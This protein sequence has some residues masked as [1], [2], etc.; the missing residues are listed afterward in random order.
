MKDSGK[1]QQTVAPA[2]VKCTVC[3]SYYLVRTTSAALSAV[4]TAYIDDNASV[5]SAL[6]RRERSVP[7]TRAS[8]AKYDMK[9]VMEEERQLLIREYSYVWGRAEKPLD[10]CTAFGK[11][12]IC[13]KF[14]AFTEQ[15][16]PKCLPKAKVDW[17]VI[18]LAP[19]TR[20]CERFIESLDKTLQAHPD[21]ALG[22]L[23]ANDLKGLTTCPV[24][25]K[26]SI[27]CYFVL[28][29]T[30]FGKSSHVFEHM[31][32]RKD[33]FVYTAPSLEMV[34][35]VAG[36]G[37][38]ASTFQK[39][40]TERAEILVIDEC[41][42]FSVERIWLMSKNFAR[43]IFIGDWTRVEN[44][45]KQ[46]T[47]L[48]TEGTAWK[49]DAAY[50]SHTHW[51]TEARRFAKWYGDL[52]CNI[53]YPLEG[54][55]GAASNKTTIVEIV[56]CESFE[57]ARNMRKQNSA[58]KSSAGITYLREEADRTTN[59][60]QPWITQKEA[61]GRTYEEVHLWD[62]HPFS[63][64]TSTCVA[65]TRMTTRLVIYV[66]QRFASTFSRFLQFNRQTLRP[67]TQAVTKVPS[68]DLQNFP[69]LEDPHFV[70]ANM[71]T[72]IGLVD[73]LEKSG[74]KLLRRKDFGVVEGKSTAE[75]KFKWLAETC[76]EI[77]GFQTNCFDFTLEFGLLERNFPLRGSGWNKAR[78][79]S[80]L[81][82]GKP[83]Q[84][85]IDHLLP[86][87]WMDPPSQPMGKK[88][89]V[90]WPYR[91]TEEFENRES[92][93][94]CTINEKTLFVVD[95]PM[96][97][98]FEGV[99]P[100]HG[101]MYPHSLNSFFR[102]MGSMYPKFN[103][104][105]KVM[106]H[107]GAHP[108]TGAKLFSKTNVR[109][110]G[111][112]HELSP[113][114]HTGNLWERYYLIVGADRDTTCFGEICVPPMINSLVQDSRI[115][116]TTEKLDY[117][118]MLLAKANRRSG[119]VWQYGSTFYFVP[120]KGP[121]SPMLS[122]KAKRMI[123]SAN[124]DLRERCV[125]VA[126]YH[127]H[128]DEGV[129]HSLMDCGLYNLYGFADHYISSGGEM[130]I[131]RWVDGALSQVIAPLASCPMVVIKEVKDSRTHRAC[132][133]NSFE[134]PRVHREEIEQT[135]SMGHMKLDPTNVK[136][137][138]VISCKAPEKIA[139]SLINRPTQYTPIRYAPGEHNAFVACV[140]RF[141]TSQPVIS[142][143]TIT[144]WFG[145]SVWMDEF[146]HGLDVIEK[147]GGFLNWASRFPSN[148][149]RAFIRARYGNE[150][151]Y[152]R[153][154][155]KHYGDQF[156]E[157]QHAASSAKI[158]GLYQF[159]PDVK[160]D[161]PVNYKMM[162]KHDEYTIN[163]QT[164]KGPRA[165][166][167]PANHYL[168]ALGPWTWSF[169]E[170]L[171]KRWSRENKIVYTAG[172][173]AEELGEVLSE[174]EYW[175]CGD[176]SGYDA[177]LQWFHIVMQILL[178][179]RFFPKPHV[180]RLLWRTVESRIRMPNFRY[181]GIGRTKSGHPGTSVLNSILTAWIFFISLKMCG[182]ENYK[183]LVSGDDTA[184]AVSIH[185]FANFEAAAQNVCQS[186]G[187]SLEG[188]VKHIYDM[189]YNAQYMYPTKDGWVLGP[190]IIRG[191]KRFI[192][193]FDSPMTIE[194]HCPQLCLAESLNLSYVPVLRDNLRDLVEEFGMADV[195]QAWLARRNRCKIQAKLHH[196]LDE[197]LWETVCAYRYGCRQISWDM[198]E[199]IELTELEYSD[200]PYVSEFGND[201]GSYSSFSGPFE[202]VKI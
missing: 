138:G 22:S 108:I 97:M 6:A 107:Y 154:M 182:I 93:A 157:E 27:S 164:T 160:E 202:V 53:W 28:G 194:E 64:T 1:T 69:A 40:C 32:L 5:Q 199:I 92:A 111:K 80:V 131:Y 201:D 200:N 185:E 165:V 16:S 91:S 12:H 119:E 58:Y 121:L 175:Y 15:A 118:K 47:V 75:R 179:L 106:D 59:S 126:T 36:K 189:D 83:T 86:Y 156:D 133:M 24:G 166:C 41:F 152:R 174:H 158:F 74:D 30:G 184:L 132:I 88:K 181:T 23:C 51:C 19:S 198:A 55:S 60:G 169:G 71:S 113:Y 191:S 21:D 116:A 153:A 137:N 127:D 109:S 176:F 140:S 52:V 61:Q 2:A 128:D 150:V 72:V 105:V 190:K 68:N 8:L 26:F 62:N 129:H 112:V 155:M 56:P 188:S 146:L 70:D 85:S 94:G 197:E 100:E 90:C 168:V 115:P 149:A 38:R 48:E 151:E 33:Q 39:V 20:G 42:A 78:I 95:C 25:E 50:E 187:L 186:T 67:V 173:N 73:T 196:E 180:V 178:V 17:Q 122:E 167:I 82:D 43:V 77:L 34:N 13:E 193:G 172:M 18:T 4:V 84:H 136:V 49:W 63:A 134:H 10:V 141:A 104:L 89:I 57:E 139:V 87:S 147:S 76:T 135:V 98:Q 29:G 35:S 124:G 65:M 101:K 114:G 99:K 46:L 170:M 7:V 161:R 37:Y 177:S 110:N 117:T 44:Q 192:Y 145:Y 79:N 81:V 123:I 125:C 143:A 195:L 9:N 130:A 103:A 14:S 96:E 120:T 159:A 66:P 163:N 183:L 171:K 102:R 148:R 45:S 162:P 11:P 142:M 54:W 144:R 3:K 31:G